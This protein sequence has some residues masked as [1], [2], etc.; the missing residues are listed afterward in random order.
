MELL[1]HRGIS[2]HFHENTLLAF[3]KALEADVKGIELDI[4][5]V[6]NDF[7]IFH[8]FHLDR[9]LSKP[10]DIRSLKQQ[11]L[12]Q[13]RL[14]D[15]QH[16]PRLNEV[17]ELVKGK[18]LLNLELK[19]VHDAAYL[20]DSISQYL[21]QFDEAEIVISSFNHPLLQSLQHLVRETRFINRIKFGALIAHLPLDLAQY[22]VNM[23]VDIAAIDADLVNKAFVEHAHIHNLEVW[24]YTVNTEKGVRELSEMGV[25][26]VFT[27]D[28]DLLRSYLPK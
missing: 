26:A 6:E 14:K 16:I 12:S 19:Y 20:L 5:Q 13:L 8:D 22:A 7:Y 1:A 4:H 21:Y 2:A 15:D 28:P 23:Q 18:C 27:N 17:F 11:E 3:E 25:D 9:L 10:G 24:S